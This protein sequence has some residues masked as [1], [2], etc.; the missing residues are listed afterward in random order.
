[1]GTTVSVV[2]EPGGERIEEE[3]VGAFA[4]L[5]ERFSRFRPDSEASQLARGHLDLA[6]ASPSMRAAYDLA[7]SWSRATK[8]AFVARRPDGTID[9]A[10]VVKAMAIRDA[11]AALDAA[12]QTDWCV[13][14]GGDVLTCGLSPRRKPWTIGISDPHDPTGYLTQFV[15]DSAYPAVA[16]SGTSE[17]GEHVWRLDGSEERD[18]PPRRLR[19]VTI[20]GPDILTADVLATAVLA[21]G[22]PLLEHV[23]RTWPVEAIVVAED[24]GLEATRAFRRDG[25]RSPANL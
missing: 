5:E 20:A 22:R 17:R 4:A 9:L 3:V 14:A 1:M 10:G 12:A 25:G 2:S 19:Q 7:E 8:G 23:L 6:D 24:G 21:G 13:N 18:A 16:T 11:G 15:C